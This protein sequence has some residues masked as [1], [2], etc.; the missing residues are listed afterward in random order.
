[1]S[2]LAL[3]G[4][5]PKTVT[6]TT[7]ET[8]TREA[9]P[10]QTNAANT[11]IA[12]LLSPSTSIAPGVTPYWTPIAVVLWRES[13][14]CVT[15]NSSGDGT[16]QLMVRESF[17]RTDL[18]TGVERLRSIKSPLQF[19]HLPRFVESADPTIVHACP[20]C[21][22]ESLRHPQLTLPSMPKEPKSAYTKPPK[23][24]LWDNYAAMRAAATAGAK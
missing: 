19:S 9:K 3:A 10:R 12:K 17:G 22:E 11:R 15:C 14:H 2:L 8:T 24:Q 1:M 6:T 18:P 23:E 16:P 21:F 20:H 13:W 4:I 5:N 7:R